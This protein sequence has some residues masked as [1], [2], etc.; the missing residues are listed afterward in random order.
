MFSP[1]PVESFPEDLTPSSNAKPLS[2]EE[3]ERILSDPNLTPSKE[4]PPLTEK[5]RQKILSD[6]NLTPSIESP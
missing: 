1:P 6:P 3:V 5:E 2:P 4:A